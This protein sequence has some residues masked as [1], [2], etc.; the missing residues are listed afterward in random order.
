M[1]FAIGSHPLDLAIFHVGCQFYQS[2]LGLETVDVDF[3]SLSGKIDLHCFSISL[4]ITSGINFFTSNQK[5]WPG[6]QPKSSVAKAQVHGV[7][8]CS[9]PSKRGKRWVR[10]YHIIRDTTSKGRSKLLSQAH[11]HATCHEIYRASDTLHLKLS[12]SENELCVFAAPLVLKCPGC[13]QTAPR[14]RHD[15]RHLFA[16]LSDLCGLG[17]AVGLHLLPLPCREGNAKPK[18]KT[19]NRGARKGQKCQKDVFY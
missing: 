12:D 11:S 6:R 14:L 2:Q 18:H 4:P 8:I 3:I 16:D 9:P 17:I 1:F 10:W 19:R 7:G 5:S 13:T 15:V